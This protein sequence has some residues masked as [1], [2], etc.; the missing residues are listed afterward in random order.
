[1]NEKLIW[2]LLKSKGT[3]PKRGVLSFTGGLDPVLNTLRDIYLKDLIPNTSGSFD[4]LIVGQYGGGKTH[5]L[6][7]M[8]EIAIQEGYV[9]SFVALSNLEDYHEIQ[10]LLTKVFG[11]IWLPGSGEGKEGAFELIQEAVD[12]KRE[13]FVQA[14]MPDPD[15]GIEQW[16]KQ[17]RFSNWPH[18]EYGKVLNRL[19]NSL[20]IGDLDMV[21]IGIEWLQGINLQANSRKMLGTSSITG[22]A[23]LRRH[24][25][26]LLMALVSFIKEAGFNGTC[27]LLDEAENAFNVKGKAKEKALSTLRNLGDTLSTHEPR[28]TLMLTAVTREVEES[29][30]DYMALQQRYARV[31]GAFSPK[32]TSSPVID[33]ADLPYDNFKI[34]KKLLDLAHK[35]YP[36]ILKSELEQQNLD[37]LAHYAESR[38][39]DVNHRRLFVKTASWLLDNNGRNAESRL[40]SEEEIRHLYD[41]QLSEILAQDESEFDIQ[42]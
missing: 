8:Q 9:T 27:L 15:A 4:K 7:A 18:P 30:I 31:A 42:D 6:R 24:G 1:M 14:E 10:S 41:G 32:N 36:D 37:I 16:I 28:C 17:L 38:S 39:F 22:K 25:L 33:L 5:F 35:I 20:L 34:G 2:E 23:N 29:F 21:E 12:K 11:G 13:T 19:L 26:Q 40:W 3:P